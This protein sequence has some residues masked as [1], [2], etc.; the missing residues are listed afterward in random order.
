MT[1]ERAGRIASFL[2]FAVP[3]G[4][5]AASAYRDVGFWDVGEMDTVPWILGIAHPTGFP[6][7]VLIGWAWSHALPFGSVALRMSLLSACAAA[8]ASWCVGRIVRDAW[9]RDP[10]LGTGCAW[11]FAFG[12][13]VWTR[14][15]RAE[16]HAV[17]ACAIALTMLFGLRWYRDGRTRDAIA[18]ALACGIGVAVHPVVALALPGTILLLA[19]RRGR[20]SARTVGAALSV[21]VLSAGIWFAY[22]PVRS[23]YVTASELD[24]TRTLGKPAGMPFW[25]Y[26][27]P[28]ALS[29]FIALVSGSQFDVLRLPGAI[30][31]PQADGR[32]A[33]FGRA[34][35][36]EF[37]W[38]GL[39]LVLCGAVV[40]WRRDWVR[41]A[42]L[43]SCGLL[44]APFALGFQAEADAERYLLPL[45][46][47][48]AIFAGDAL[49]AAGDRWP[50]SR[51][52]AAAVPVLL[53]AWLLLQQQWL[54]A[55]PHD[56]RAR[57]SIDEVQSL[58]P[59]NA[60]LVATWV[61]APALAYATYV[62][63]SMGGRTLDAAW[64]ADDA[65]YVP[66]WIKT[67]PV[68][69]VGTPSGDIPGF[70]LESRSSREP[71]FEIVPR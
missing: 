5:F 38:P 31:T 45:F 34:V 44:A 46:F 9:P 21:F 25:D 47:A 51:E 14:A 16:V 3:L 22:L 42:Y 48:G 7:Y 58:T 53:A 10:W 57:A 67:R 63:G 49:G 1:H 27:H 66:G 2:A 54:F 69:V 60:I 36:S 50:R 40:A 13:V 61:Y 32:I 23:A 19:A 29:G 17:A 70:R 30:P 56:V 8:A 39:L 65:R 64:L 41:C 55:Q 71:L 35:A 52:A 4:V 20:T 24:P 18:S 43:A 33:A 68:Y 37:T 12:L 62:E 6:A 15:T 28:A 11:L 59:P 26:D